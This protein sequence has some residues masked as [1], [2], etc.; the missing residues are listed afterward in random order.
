[1]LVPGKALFVAKLAGKR[2]WGAVHLFLF[3]FHL[4][5]LGVCGHFSWWPNCIKCPVEWV[6]SLV[7]WLWTHNF[8]VCVKSEAR[9]ERKGGRAD[10]QFQQTWLVGIGNV[11]KHFHFCFNGTGFQL[12]S[13]SPSLCSIIILLGFFLSLCIGQNKSHFWALHRDTWIGGEWIGLQSEEDT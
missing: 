4:H 7:S 1:M 3:P 11:G 9:R 13:S 6:H 8:F 5:K 12:L 10:L 2:V